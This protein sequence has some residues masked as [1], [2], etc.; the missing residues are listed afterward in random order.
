MF[1]SNTKLPHLL[2]SKDYWCQD[3]YDAE[4]NECLLNSWHFVGTTAELAKPGDFISRQIGG[5]PIQVRNF[6]GNLQALSNVCAHRH[7]LI[8]SDECG[9]SPRMRCQ[10]HG[11]EYQVD[12][13]TGRI[14]QPKNFVPFCREEVRLP[15]YQTTVL[16]QL[17]FVCVGDQPQDLEASLGPVVFERLHKHFDQGWQLG[18]SWTTKVDV[19]WKIPI[20]NALESYHVPAV[21]A[22][23]FREDPGS[24]RTDHRL[25]DNWTDMTTKLPFAP[26]HWLDATFQRVE[27]RYVRWLGFKATGNYQQLHV[28]PNLLFSFTDAISLA[29]CILPLGPKRSVAVTR[30]F[31]RL[32]ASERGFSGKFKRPL[33]K[34]WGKMTG[35]ISQRIM[36]EDLDI[37][38]AIQNGIEHSSHQGILGACEERIHRFQRY[39]IDQGGVQ[40][41][42][43]SSPENVKD[44]SND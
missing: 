35:K 23:T 12:G 33:A 1:L 28:F 2:S 13:R 43:E 6:E 31:G 20:E 30:H 40:L 34:A 41:T 8:S 42:Q 17:V 22:N 19:N 5:I 9:N 24:E 39:I 26:H 27:A 25:A 29:Q 18:S 14:P 11:W 7:A 44:L 36:L 37:W 32:P 21:H 38:S 10:Y 3:R 16:G 4:L 15:V